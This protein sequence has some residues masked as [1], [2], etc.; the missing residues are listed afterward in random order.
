MEKTQIY[1]VPTNKKGISTFYSAYIMTA[2]GIKLLEPEETNNDKA[3]KEMGFSLALPRI[4]GPGRYCIEAKGNSSHLWMATEQVYRILK[5][6]GIAVGENGYVNKETAT[7]NLLGGTRP[8]T[9]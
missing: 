6:M 2:E 7:V 9:Y 3:G 5:N 1:L 8:M 4:I